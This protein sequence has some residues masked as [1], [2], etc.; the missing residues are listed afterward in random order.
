VARV[1]HA[2]ASIRRSPA[3]TAMD[4]LASA[5]R[6]GQGRAQPGDADPHGVRCGARRLL[7]PEQVDEPVHRYLAVGLQ[8]EDRQH[9]ALL[10][11]AER[12]GPTVHAGLH[13]TQQPQLQ[14]RHRHDRKP[15][16]DCEPILNGLRHAAREVDPSAGHRGE[17]SWH[18][19]VPSRAGPR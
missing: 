17:C 4:R 6:R 12:D 14:H 13:R 1:W 11:G 10:A 2:S 9:E 19:W 3:S 5:S 18:S 8:R 16:P 15:G 7:R